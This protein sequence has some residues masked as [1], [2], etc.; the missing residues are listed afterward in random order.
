MTHTDLVNGAL[1]VN[2]KVRGQQER[3]TEELSFK[4]HCTIDRTKPFRVHKDVSAAVSL[5]SIAPQPNATSAR[6]DGTTHRKATLF[7]Q[8]SIE[9]KA[10][11]CAIG[12]SH[13]NDR[14]LSS[15]QQSKRQ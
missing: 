11:P 4:R 10:F 3:Q 14:N 2:H 5:D 7:V 1:R 13:T 8:H 12:S 6:L 15:P 9:Q